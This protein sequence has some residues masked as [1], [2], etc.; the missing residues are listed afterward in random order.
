[1][2]VV[3]PPRGRFLGVAGEPL[4]LEEF[5]HELMPGM[6]VAVRY[7]RWLFHERVL[8]YPV[9]MAGVDPRAVWRIV[10]PEFDE[11]D[12]D[13][14]L[15]TDDG[16]VP[17][18][19][20]SYTA[21]MIAYLR[22]RFYRLSPDDYPEDQELVPAI[23]DG[24]RVYDESNGPGYNY[25]NYVNYVGELE[26]IPGRRREEPGRRDRPRSRH[27]PGEEVLRERGPPIDAGGGRHGQAFDPPP[28]MVWICA[29]A[30][31]AGFDL[32]TTVDMKGT[33]IRLDEKVGVLNREPGW[34]RVFA[35]RETEIPEYVES[36]LARRPSPTPRAPDA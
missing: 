22:R 23:Q 9:K 27:G 7:D 35:M 25:V 14:S 15:S 28:G 4:E 1:M 32:G 8:K 17:V 21:D 10:T 33:D 12:E 13:Y 30:G 19:L 11:Y 31:H 2:A 18:G 6:V 20:L 36:V 16:P 24:L 5:L 29:E 34:C 3:V 26:D